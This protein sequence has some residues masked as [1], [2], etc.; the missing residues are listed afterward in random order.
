MNPLI[1]RSS[2]KMDMASDEEAELTEPTAI[3]LWFM[4]QTFVSSVFIIVCFMLGF[5]MNIAPDFVAKL[6]GAPDKQQLNH[7]AIRMCG[8]IGAG[9]LSTGLLFYCLLIE[10]TSLLKAVQV[11]YAFWFY[12]QARVT[13]AHNYDDPSMMWASVGLF[14]FIVVAMEVLTEDKAKLTLQII[15]AIWVAQAPIFIFAPETAKK[16]WKSNVGEPQDNESTANTRTSDRAFGF[17]LLSA[18]LN[19]GALSL[20]TTEYEAI[21]HAV[22]CYGAGIA[23]CI[24][25]GELKAAGMDVRIMLAWL[26]F[27]GFVAYALLV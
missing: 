1:I 11:I 26:L 24:V 21:G 8:Q 17:W 10:K 27:D 3:P 7:R 16:L 20:G 15:S 23:S 2:A 5:V 14:G 13:V 19:T 22:I 6:H 25:S 4:D 12:H 9:H 18:G